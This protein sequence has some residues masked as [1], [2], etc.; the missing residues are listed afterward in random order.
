MV[1]K[2][3]IEMNLRFL[4]FI[5]LQL[6]IGFNQNEEPD[7]DYRGVTDQSITFGYRLRHIRV[8]HE[9]ELFFLNFK[10]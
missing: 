8:S 7:F 6:Q 10:K 9:K 2:T 1:V 4:I 3:V 5:F